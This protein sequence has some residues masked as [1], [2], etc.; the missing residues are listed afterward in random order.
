MGESWRDEYEDDNFREELEALLEQL[1]PLYQQLHTYV[2]KRL[3]DKYGKDHFPASGHIP[4]H[5]LGEL[6][7]LVLLVVEVVVVVV[8]VVVLV[9]VLLLLLLFNTQGS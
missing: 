3:M 5:I 8:V 9:L 7:M 6:L 1:H 4:A 2:R